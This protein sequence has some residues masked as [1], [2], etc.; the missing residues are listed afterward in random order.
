MKWAVTGKQE[1][2]VESVKSKKFKEGDEYDDVDE[3][4]WSHNDTV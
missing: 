2:G 3:R 4:K 1:G